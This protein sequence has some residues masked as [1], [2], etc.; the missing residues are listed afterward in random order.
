MR[1]RSP[2]RKRARSELLNLAEAPSEK[3][4]LSAAKTEKAAELRARYDA[5]ARQADKPGNQPKPAGFTPPK[6]WGQQD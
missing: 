2:V 1:F 6:V 5:L 3:H 4:D